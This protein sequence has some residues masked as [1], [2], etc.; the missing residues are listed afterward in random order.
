ML[1][2]SRKEDDDQDGTLVISKKDQDDALVTSREE[3]DD[4]GC[5]LV[6]SSRDLHNDVWLHASSNFNIKDNAL[7][8][9][10]ENNNNNH[11]DGTLVNSKKEKFDKKKIPVPIIVSEENDSAINRATVVGTTVANNK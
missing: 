10:R 8:I 2:T 1:V 5:T 3:D 6:T 4:Q 9:S 7:I 11:K